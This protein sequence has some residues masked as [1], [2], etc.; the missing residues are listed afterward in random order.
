MLN[1]NCLLNVSSRALEVPCKSCW[2]AGRARRSQ[3]QTRALRWGTEARRWKHCLMSSDLQRPIIARRQMQILLCGVTK[4]CWKNPH[5]WR[6][7][8][9]QDLLFLWRSCSWHLREGG[10]FPSI[11]GDVREQ[12]CAALIPSPEHTYSSW[13]SARSFLWNIGKNRMDAVH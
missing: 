9:E 11:V 8:K 10:G 6:G 5:E 13:L 1:F 4:T 2:L 12:Q 7:A 3:W